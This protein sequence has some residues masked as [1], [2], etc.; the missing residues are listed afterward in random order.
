VTAIENDGRA[1]LRSTDKRYDL[2]IFALPDSLTL[3]SSTANIRLESFLFTEEAFASVRDHLTQTGVFVLYNYYRE[4]WLVTKIGGMLTDA[5]HGPPILKTFDAQMAILAAGPMIDALGGAA[6]PG[7]TVKPLPVIDAP[8][9]KPATDDW[10][11]L[12]LRTP[13]IAGYYLLALAFVVGMAVF[14]VAACGQRRQYAAAAVQPPLL[15]ARDGVP[16]AGDTEPRELQP[17][18]RLDVVRQ[19]PG[20]LRDSRLRARRDPRERASPAP[21]AGCPVRIA[22]RGAGGR[23]RDPAGVAADQPGLAA[24]PPRRGAGLARRCSWQISC[25]R[26][27]SE[28]PRRP[29]MAFASNL[30]GAMVGGA[31]EYLAL[32]TGYRVLLIVVALLYAVAWLFATRWRRL[33]D[34]DL[35]SEPGDPGTEIGLEANAG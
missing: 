18:V 26:I 34:V 16:L 27:R 35:A 2:I 7:D 3:V 13:D 32:L 17:A 15:R 14:A 1:Y 29:D 31:L 19:R 24:V 8:A 4:P 28:T 6:P 21:A 23:V 11:F 30:L 12:Y 10:P 5:F 25:S 9:P 22:V 33:A 20:V